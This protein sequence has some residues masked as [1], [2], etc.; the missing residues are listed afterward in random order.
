MKTWVRRS[1]N[2]G[3][4]SAGF[5]LIGGAA[6]AQA[7]DL[8]TGNNAGVGNGNQLGSVLQLPVDISGNAVGVGGFAD[9]SSTGGAKATNGGGGTESST[10][11][12]NAGL[13][14]GN[15]LSNVVQ[16]PVSACGNAIA[17]LGFADASCTGGAGA[18][19]GGG[20]TTGSGTG[21]GSGSGYGESTQAGA[22]AESGTMTSGYNAGI[23]S[24]N[25]VSNVI[26]AP[27][28][29]CGN[30]ISLA[31]FAKANCD[32]GADATNNGSESMATGFNAGIL[33][34]NQVSN[35][36]QV[37][38]SVCGN[39]I[40][41]LGFADASCTGGASANNGGSGSGSGSGAGDT[42]TDT[43]GD[44][45]TDPTAGSSGG[46]GG[47]AGNGTYAANGAATGATGATSATSAT[48]AAAKPAGT[49]AKA[50][51][52]S[53]A[54]KKANAAK[55]AKA[56]KH[57]G[58]NAKALGARGLSASAKSA[59]SAS[60]S[61][62]AMSAG[63]GMISGYNAGLL[64]GNQVSSVV[65]V[66]VDISGNAVSILGFAHAASVGGSTATNG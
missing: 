46:Y 62:H 56:S 33:S 41:L 16:V 59:K 64:N 55:K 5:L 47:A 22:L 61:A 26:Q 24:G 23:G 39:S 52:H 65:Q 20:D 6:A 12:Y 49:T 19:N 3:V 37:P 25:Q 13:L 27:I 51:K 30:A 9:A 34:G 17:V 15:Q 10:T 7:A 1:L 60:A 2:V 4:L 48:S 28:D 57:N 43:P 50:A 35:V 14:S 40:A 21:S 45:T 31:G 11:G 53:H 8:T 38:V 63:G 32:G 58:E 42:T 66:P 36:V 29:L 18:T 44:D 54:A